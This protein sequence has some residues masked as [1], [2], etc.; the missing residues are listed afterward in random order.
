MFL[1]VTQR[2]RSSSVHRPEA[3]RDKQTGTHVDSTVGLTA[4]EVFILL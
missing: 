4:E 1:C 2:Q 3:Q